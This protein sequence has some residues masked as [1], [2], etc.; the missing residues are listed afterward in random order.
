MSSESTLAEVVE[1]QGKKI[2]EQ[3]K[4]ILELKEQLVALQELQES[5]YGRINYLQKAFKLGL[6][7]EGTTVKYN[8]VVV[9]VT[10]KGERAFLY[11]N[12]KFFDSFYKFLSSVHGPGQYKKLIIDGVSYKT[13][14]ECLKASNDKES[15]MSLETSSP[16]NS[17]GNVIDPLLTEITTYFVERGFQSSLVSSFLKRRSRLEFMTNE[18]IMFDFLEEREQMDPIIF[19]GIEGSEGVESG[20]DKELLVKWGLTEESARNL[21]HI[22]RNDTIWSQQVLKHW[23]LKWIHNLWNSLSFD[24]IF[25]NEEKFPRNQWNSYERKGGPQ[26]FASSYE[27]I[28]NIGKDTLLINNTKVAN[29]ANTNYQAFFHATDYQSAQSIS[30]NGINPYLGRPCL[31]FG[32]S[33]SFYLNPSLEN[34]IDFIR[35]RVGFYAIIIYWVDTERVKSMAYRDLVPNEE[36]WKEV[37]VASRC[38][39]RSVIESDKFVYGYQMSN[40]RQILLAWQAYGGEDVEN[41]WRN[42]IQEA[43]WFNP[44]RHLQLAVKTEDA[45]ELINSY[46]VGIIY[47][48]TKDE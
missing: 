17:T 6:I 21:R 20:K 24:N 16:D 37:V 28:I 33:P 45:A 7:K 43:R 18:E 47:F 42:H 8:T 48:H 31:D 2:L 9:K 38:R 1:K 44:V 10:V 26:M 27:Y 34:A 30:K 3:G 5:V 32:R 46:R 12:N 11:Y 22:V 29:Q 41:S 13:F 39:Q 36:L 23:L 14:L 40:P 15:N 35:N 4:E 19:I 25:N